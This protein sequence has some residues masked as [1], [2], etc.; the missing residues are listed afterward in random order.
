MVCAIAIG[1]RLNAIQHG[2]VDMVLLSLGTIKLENFNVVEVFDT[3][4]V[5]RR[6]DDDGLAV[7][8]E[9]SWPK[10][11]A[12]TNSEG[13]SP[14]GFCLDGY[15]FRDEVV[16]DWVEPRGT[17]RGT[18]IELAVERSRRQRIRWYKG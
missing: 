7:S 11:I 3:Y 14:K 12:R 4:S 6:I 8:R 17:S 18:A 10:I 2:L 9:C 16:G 5:D 15:G 13:G 1:V